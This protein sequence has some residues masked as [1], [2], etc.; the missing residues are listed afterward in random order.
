MATKKVRETDQNV[1]NL[2]QASALRG[3]Q[4]LSAAMQNGKYEWVQPKSS[5]LMKTP[6]SLRVLAK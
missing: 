5:Y 1:L 3:V 6:K 4:L 2:K